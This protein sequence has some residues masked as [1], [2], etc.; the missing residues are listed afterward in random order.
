M[1]RFFLAAIILA[2]CA[3]PQ[4]RTAEVTEIRTIGNTPINTIPVQRPPTLD[5]PSSMRPITPSG[6]S[7][8]SA[9]GA[10][11]ETAKQD[12]LARKMNLPF[13]PAIAMDPVDGSK[14]SITPD[15]P[16]VEHK[17]RIYYF[18]SAKNRQAF[19]ANPDGYLKDKFA[20]Y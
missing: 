12:E 11:E 2:A 7:K 16:M 14:V 17:D 19:L 1:K 20:S 9:K 15:T 18:S 10:A 4:A 6:K 8:L 13:A 5:E 3:R